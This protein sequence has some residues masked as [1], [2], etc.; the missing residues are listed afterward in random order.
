MTKTSRLRHRQWMHVPLSL[1]LALAVGAAQADGDLFAA[2]NEQWRAECAS[3]HV[4]YPPQLLPASSWRALMSGLDRHFG[5]DASLDAKTAAEIG[6]FLDRHAAREPRSGAGKPPLRITETA[7]FR[8]EH[9]EVPAATWHD[10][11][12]ESPANCGA[13]HTQA[14]AGDYRERSLRVPK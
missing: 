6:A 10:A 9:D 4:A 5:S 1:A 7:W 11:K 3:C 14:D 13:C 2:T 12:V 8:H